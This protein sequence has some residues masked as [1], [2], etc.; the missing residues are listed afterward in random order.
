M[1]VELIT[2]SI[3]DVLARIIGNAL[4]SITPT[5]TSYNF[6]VGKYVY[7]IG[8]KVKPYYSYVRVELELNHNRSDDRYYAIP[9]MNT[10][11]P[12]TELC[13]FN[14]YI[15]TFLLRHIPELRTS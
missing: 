8:I 6:T 12:Y 13:K 3:K 14:D 15:H 10:K 11:V 9:T 5:Y 7:Q 4:F 1:N 2:I